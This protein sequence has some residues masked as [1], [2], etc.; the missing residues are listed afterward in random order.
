VRSIS[1]DAAQL[2]I[3]VDHG[4]GGPRQSRTGGLRVRAAAERLLFLGSVAVQLNA[5]AYDWMAARRKALTLDDYLPGRS[6]VDLLVVG[7]ALRRRHSDPA[8]VARLLTLVRAR[9]AEAR[10]PS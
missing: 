10:R 9:L 6:D 3:A 1:F 8:Q 5:G 2:A 4:D 7:D